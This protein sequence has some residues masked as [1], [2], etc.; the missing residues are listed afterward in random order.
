MQVIETKSEGLTRE[1]KITLPATEIEEKIIHRLK[2]I[3]RTAQLPGFRPGKVPATM[4]RKRY[5]GSVL[6]EIV[7]KAIGDSSQQV[8]TERGIRPAM[9]PQIEIISYEDGT[10]LEY[11]MAVDT[12]PEIETGD[13]S[14]IKLER[15]VPEMDPAAID[16]AL[17]NIADANKTSTPITKKR[18]SKSGDVVIIDFV[19]SVDG[20]EFP[21]G[22]ADAYSLELGSSSFIPGFEDQLIGVN[23]GEELEVK[24]VFPEAYGGAELAGKDAVFKVT[25]KEIHEAATADINDELARGVG[26][27]SLDKLKEAITSEQGREYTNLSRVRLKRFLLDQLNESYKFEVPTRMVDGEFEVIWKQYEES[28]AE[29]A[30]KG[31]SAEELSDK[32]QKSE[33]REIAERR[34]RLGLLLAEVGRQ[35][36]IQVSQD[37]INRRIMEEARQHQGQEQ[38]VIDY[39]KKNPEAIEQITAPLYEEKVV[40]FIVELATVKDKKVTTE[41]LFK[42]LEADNEAD[43]KNPSKPNGNSKNKVD[44]AATKVPT[45]KKSTVKKAPT[46]KKPAAKSK[47]DDA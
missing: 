6:G 21:G 32:E 36:N 30:E 2:E 24:V 4:L 46:K 3:G 13:F 11:S 5:G 23:A 20:E 33:F 22:K 37:D 40:D 26:M 42:I 44:A 19:G 17:K 41:E 35:N 14:K 43:D 8:L 45:K 39:Y 12:L 25:I 31:D 7:E 1:Y 9:Q 28:K 27:E 18:K 29:A 16:T 10:D 47:T 38:M 15:L 34:V